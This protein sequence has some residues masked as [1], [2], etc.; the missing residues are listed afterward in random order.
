MR[1]SIVSLIND[2]GGSV[3]FERFMA[4]ALYH[5]HLGYYSQYVNSVGASGDFTTAP[6]LQPALAKSLASHTIG[7]YRGEEPVDNSLAN[8]LFSSCSQP[9]IPIVE[10]GPGTGALAVQL[11]SYLE[12]A[13]SELD[14]ASSHPPTTVRYQM[15]EVS[16]ALRTLQT[17]RVTFASD[18]RITVQHADSLT[19]AL[20]ATGG[21]AIVLSN[22]LVDAF[23]AVQLAW[24]AEQ[25]HEVW[26][27]ADGA[28]LKE[29]L[30]PLERR[31]D[32][33]VPAKPRDGQRVFCHPSYHHW[34]REQLAGL[35]YGQLITIDYGNCYVASECRAYANQQRFEGAAIYEKPGQRDLT[36]DVNFSDLQRWGDGMGMRT[37]SC[38]YLYQFLEQHLQTDVMA[39]SRDP[40]QAALVRF[41]NP[42]EVG[43]AYRVLIQSPST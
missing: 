9:C 4:L 36:C 37:R 11:L 12:T 28:A 14:A 24:H 20:S 27:D 2:E 15:V 23:P 32:A 16:P 7:L 5:P 13:L 39:A 33:E 10:V 41:L 25:W 30:R 18:S 29:S 43:G 21:R 40:Q 31:F 42:V 34:M 26:V 3:T 22:E 38:D 35:L 8:Q 19:A 17:E 1:D 6:E